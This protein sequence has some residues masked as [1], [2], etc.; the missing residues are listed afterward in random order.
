M[1]S[2]SPSSSLLT[3]TVTCLPLGTNHRHALQ[4]LVVQTDGTFRVQVPF[5]DG[6][7]RDPAGVSGPHARGAGEHAR[8]NPA[9]LVLNIDPGW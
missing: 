5:R 1:T 7:Q 2:P 9:G 3:N 4:E 6:E 8:A